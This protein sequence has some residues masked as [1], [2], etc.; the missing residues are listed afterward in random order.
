QWQSPPSAVGGF[1]FGLVVDGRMVG[2]QLTRH[3][4]VPPAALLGSGISQ[5]RVLATDRL[6]G[7]VLSK[8]VKLRVD[9]RPPVLRVGLHPRRG[10]VILR[11]RDT[12]SGLAQGSIR[13]SFG[14]GSRS[15]RH[16]TIHHRYARAGS[17]TIRVTARD[18]VGNRLVQRVEVGVR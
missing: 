1:T 13:V 18:R 15:R 5:V 17:Y 14:D 2:A 7:E 6:G 11:L 9:A 3:R 4:V 12:Q 16:A 10:Q 8:P